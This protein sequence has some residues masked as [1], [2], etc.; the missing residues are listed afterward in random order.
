M[1]IWASVINILKEIMDIPPNK[2]NEVNTMKGF[3]RKERIVET[4]MNKIWLKQN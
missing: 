3:T 2:E 4:D 1:I